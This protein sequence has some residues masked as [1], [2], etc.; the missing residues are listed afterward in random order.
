MDV[1]DIKPTEN[2]TTE[3]EETKLLIQ[4]YIEAGNTLKKQQIEN[5]TPNNFVDKI[6]EQYK[7]DPLKTSITRYNNH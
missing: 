6:V 2:T 1:I 7:I 4:Q 3:N 5:L